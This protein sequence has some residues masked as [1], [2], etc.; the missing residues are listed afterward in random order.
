MK[1]TAQPATVQTGDGWHHRI[2]AVP[3]IGRKVQ[4]MTTAGK[5]WTAKVCKASPRSTFRGIGCEVAYNI[6]MGLLVQ[7]DQISHWRY[8]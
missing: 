1:M 7:A 2:D 8:C 6:G 3:Q 5:E 4:I